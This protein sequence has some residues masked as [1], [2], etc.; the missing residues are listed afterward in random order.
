[1][2]NS[3]R[4]LLRTKVQTAL[5][6]LLV[7]LCAL[8]V[9]L[10]TNLSKQCRDNIER[11]KDVF[12]TI[13]TVEQTPISVARQPFYSAETKDYTYYNVKEYGDLVSLSQLE[14]PDVEYI[15]GPE[16]RPF[17]QSYMPDYR[18]IDLN[19][20]WSNRIIIE[21]T[22][23]EDGVPDGPLKMH[24]DRVLYS[25]YQINVDYI[26]F[27]DH[28]NDN[29][30]MMY[31]DKT[32]I[33]CL[34]DSFWHR[35][36]GSNDAYFPWEYVPAG[37][38]FS[39]QAASDTMLMPSELTGNSF[40]EI[41]DEYYAKGHDKWW[42][43]YAN[44]M[45][46]YYHTVPVTVA[47]DMNLIMQFFNGDVAISDGRN[48]EKDD[49]ENGNKNCLL[50][51]RFARR[52][53]IKV[54]DTVPLVLH[55]ANYA[56]T[57]I[58]EWGMVALTANGEQFSTFFEAD[59]TVVGIYSPMPG[60]DTDEGYLFEDNEI[61]IPE[62]SIT[63]DNSNSIGVLGDHISPYNTSFRIENGKIDE[64]LAS[65]EKAGIKDLTIRFYDKG[66]SLLEEGIL[67]TER[68]AYVLL[69]AG[70]FMTVLVLLF[71]SHMMISGQKKRTA[72]ERSLGAS[73]KQCMTSLLTGI[74]LT[75]AVGCIA[76]CIAGTMLTST[77]AS[78]LAET[79]DFDRTFSAGIINVEGEPEEQQMNGDF[80][81]SA[82][83]CGGIMLFT[84]AVSGAF[85]WKNLKEE[86]LALL[87][88]EKN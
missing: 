37:G 33:M 35:T 70:I 61:F 82:A 51:F 85:A 32:Y 66:Y 79:D 69:G 24:I 60:G 30:Q 29:P 8:L 41:N 84:A 80:V 10:G 49:F 9:C 43:N 2:K 31:K 23:Y 52:N 18:M 6:L 59:Y 87:S 56:S 55:Y 12:V 34:I 86:P 50:S 81:I 83:A 5:F 65:F 48:L 67:Q 27:C 16:R 15:S 7:A 71:F 14:L 42:Q 64:F 20:G 13:G 53:N 63:A 62:R 11:L 76:G 21:A 57:P 3:L 39:E 1:M 17:Y 4:Q 72:I 58:N 25:Y 74:W 38:P 45:D 78:N 28:Y 77:V 73:K 68:M 75:A 36:S 22:P 47:N 88:G 19:A 40:E 26:Y 44:E 46:L 54:G